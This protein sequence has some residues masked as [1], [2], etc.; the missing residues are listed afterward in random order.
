MKKV[1]LTFVALLFS[2]SFNSQILVE[3]FE[4]G[5][6]ADTI[7]GLTTNWITYSG[8]KPAFYQP[9]PSLI[10]SGYT[11]NEIGG[12]VVLG[13]STLSAPVGA[14]TGDCKY[15]LGSA[16]YI[17]TGTAFASALINVSDASTIGEYFFHFTN[18]TSNFY[19]RLAV[20]KDANNNLFF[21]VTRAGGTGS[22]VTYGTTSFMIN[23]TYLA[24]IKYDYTTAESKL[25]I[26]SATSLTEPSTAEAVNNSGTTPT[27]A[28]QAISLR[29]GIFSNQAKVRVDAIKVATNW[30]ALFENSTPSISFSNPTPSVN[31][32][33]GTQTI[34]INISPVSSNAESIDV[35]IEDVTA[36]NGSDYTTNPSSTTFT[37]NIPA[38][39]SSVSFE[40][41]ITDDAIE[42]SNETFTATL[43]NP[44]SGLTII[45]TNVL[46]L[47]I[48]DNDAALI[49]T[50]IYDIQYTTNVDSTSMLVGQTVNTGGIVSAIT[51]IPT[52]SKG[53]WINASSGG[54]WS[55]IKVFYGSSSLPSGLAI[56]DSVTFTA[57]VDEYTNF[58]NPTSKETELKTV[59]NFINVN[60]G[61]SISQT[62]ISTDDG[63]KKE[64]YEGVLVTFLNATATDPINSFGEYKINDGSG[65]ATIDTLLYDPMLI[66]NSIYNVTGIVSKQGN[67]YNNEIY[68]RFEADVVLVSGAGI[69]ENTELIS[70]V[71]PSLVTD[72]VYVD[73]KTKSDLNIMSMDGKI[74]STFNNIE[75]KK[76]IDLSFLTSGMYI[77][78]I[79]S[80][81]IKI[82]KK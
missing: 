16:N 63:F 75:G 12:S 54:E 58:T 39:S 32:N 66:L 42:E 34:T 38:N 31:E 24:V 35:T 7:T 10:L 62:V 17:S 51:S 65:K 59:S 18:S 41:N 74:Q 26:L 13:D 82:I 55:G 48:L 79:G 8:K 25:Y 28:I 4:Y 20:K 21:G 77:V 5:V 69:D 78:N 43:L 57:V 81:S 9:S 49:Y 45:G 40:V 56:G 64:K 23:T 37:I 11:T 61:N 73:C 15:D 60:S 68:P 1:Y 67:L 29:Q 76:Q 27:G 46:T 80:K 44:S 36:T 52:S 70:S 53:F 71:Y 14:S 22:D 33:I 47:T 2:A 19:S 30:A 6:N 72:F 3:N 50:P